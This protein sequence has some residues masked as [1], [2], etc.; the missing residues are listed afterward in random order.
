MSG[1]PL[2][3]P[4]HPHARNEHNSHAN[5]GRPPA[6]GAVDERLFTNRRIAL[7]ALYSYRIATDSEIR[8]YLTFLESDAGHWLLSTLRQSWLA[9]VSRTAITLASEITENRR[10]GRII[11]LIQNQ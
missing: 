3:Q 7:R 6:A 9:A 8:Q 4:A 2:R 1:W 10:T 5:S 11:G